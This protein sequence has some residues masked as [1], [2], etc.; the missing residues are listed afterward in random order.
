[1]IFC[2]KRASVRREFLSADV[3]FRQLPDGAGTVGWTDG[4]EQTEES[5]R[6]DC[7]REDSS[8]IFCLRIFMFSLA[9]FFYFDFSI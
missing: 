2:L 7:V 1:M 9:E 3:S 8:D 4:Q 5:S 6:T